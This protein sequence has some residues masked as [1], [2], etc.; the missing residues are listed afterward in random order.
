MEY[1]QLQLNYF[2][3]DSEIVQSGACYEA[4]AR[5][6]KPVIVMEPVKGGVLAKVPS[7]IEALFRGKQPDLSDASW[8]IRYAAS[9]DNVMM[10][11][12]GMSNMEQME[13]NISYMEHFQ[14]LD[15]EE[16][17]IIEEAVHIYDR[18]KA[19]DCINCGK[20]L[21]VCPEHIPVASYFQMY[22]DH[23]RMSLADQEA[24]LG[25]FKP[26]D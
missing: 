7:E 11:L 21:P 8:A 26:A 2:D 5:H 15:A 1:V 9:L 24:M 6:H 25:A 14:P 4:A 17:K 18:Q 3:W 10:V 20:C 13:D 23:C 19:V 22:N 16:Q 12:S